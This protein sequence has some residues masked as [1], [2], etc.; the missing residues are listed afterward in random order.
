MAVTRSR[1]I[2]DWWRLRDYTPSVS[3]EAL[4]LR[5]GLNDYGT[6][7]FYVHD[8]I[9]LD[10]ATFAEK[11]GV[12]EATIVLG[13][14]LSNQNI[15]LFDV[16]E[17]RLAGVKEVTAAHEMLH[18]A[19]DRLSPTEQDELGKLLIETFNALDNTRI[20]D[21]VKTYQA[22]DG[23][24]VVNELHSILGT[25]V[26]DLPQPLEEHYK[27]Y[28]KDRLAVV[29]L[30]EAYSSEFTRRQ[31]AVKEYD[32]Q[33]GGIQSEIT[34]IEA[35]I[36][37]QAEALKIE[38]T[39]LEKLVSDPQAYNAAVDIY[40]KKVASYNND[41]GGLKSLIETYNTIVKE[42]NE[43]ALEERQLVDAID[44]RIENIVQ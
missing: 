11:C 15:Y 38:R 21:T 5:A 7:L 39:L 19:F 16:Q 10:K 43:I 34:R 36:T 2:I 6:K 37:Q 1:D 24:I 44:T 35:D 12:G 33:L 30:S 18:A 28:F 29:S 20:E 23:S 27:R 41:I 31:D 32:A 25:E 8:P 17:D 9:L 14:Y 13:C 4:A 3:V 26:R 40:N 42:R 22:R